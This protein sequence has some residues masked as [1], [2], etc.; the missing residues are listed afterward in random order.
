MGAW[1]MEDSR[2][3]DVAEVAG[4][5]VATASKALNGRQDVSAVTRDKVHRPR[6]CSRSAPT[7]PRSSCR[8]VPQARWA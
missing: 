2:L 4:V 5:S 7:V 3:K 1:G 8:A 6:V